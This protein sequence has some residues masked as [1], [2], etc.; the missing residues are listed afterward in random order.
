MGQEEKFYKVETW[1]KRGSGYRHGTQ[2]C[3]GSELGGVVREITIDGRRLLG[4]LR[5]GSCVVRDKSTGVIVAIHGERSNIEGGKLAGY[6]KEME[7]RDA[8]KQSAGRSEGKD[9]RTERRLARPPRA[10]RTRR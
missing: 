4:G 2:V 1:F 7:L 10:R 6:L 9:S 5:I 8:V 3:T